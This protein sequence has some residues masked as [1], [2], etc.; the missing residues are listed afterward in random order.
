[1]DLQYFC[2]A[3]GDGNGNGNG[4]DVGNPVLVG[5]SKIFG[6]TTR[7]PPHNFHSWWSVQVAT[8]KVLP[9]KQAP[10]GYGSEW[11][12]TESIKMIPLTTKQST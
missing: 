7:P 12:L 2:Q 9:V 1:M 4:L 11:M 6:A 5:D 10:S 3:T 8:K